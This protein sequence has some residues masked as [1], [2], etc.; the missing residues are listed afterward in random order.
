MSD[1]P[2]NGDDAVTLPSPPTDFVVAE[3]EPFQ[4][5]SSPDLQARKPVP[6]PT[7]RR[8][9]LDRRLFAAVLSGP[10]ERQELHPSAC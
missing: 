8:Y 4:R 9:R 1:S 6:T 10:F 2:S 5:R 3:D 7:S